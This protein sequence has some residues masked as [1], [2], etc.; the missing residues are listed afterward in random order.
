MDKKGN[1][2]KSNDIHA[3][4]RGDELL[5]KIALTVTKRETGGIL[6]KKGEDP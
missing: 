2:R 3:Q 5:K 1:F 6:Q 4:E